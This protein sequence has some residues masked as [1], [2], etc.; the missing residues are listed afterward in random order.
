MIILSLTSRIIGSVV[1]TYLGR[2]SYT[3]SASRSKIIADRV[4]RRRFKIGNARE[5]TWPRFLFNYLSRIYLIILKERSWAQDGATSASR[6]PFLLD[7]KLFINCSR[8][9]ETRVFLGRYI[10]IYIYEPRR[11]AI[12]L[13]GIVAVIRTD[14]SNDD[15]IE[16]D[17]IYRRCAAAFSA[18]S[19]QTRSQK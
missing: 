6:A 2:Y 15:P 19:P 4:S 10:Y 16:E 17:Q 8:I 11:F 3:R 9:Y 7:C 13:I 14:S 18:L 12:I 5:R 1:A